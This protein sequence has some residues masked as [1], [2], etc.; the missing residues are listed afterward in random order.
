MGTSSVNENINGLSIAMFD[1]RRVDGQTLGGLSEVPEWRIPSSSIS[2]GWVKKHIRTCKGK[3][4]LDVGN[5]RCID[6]RRF[7]K[8]F[9]FWSVSPW[10]IRFVSPRGFPWKLISLATNAPR[11]SSGNAAPFPMDRPGPL[12]DVCWVDRWPT[13]R[14]FPSLEWWEYMGIYGNWIREII[15]GRMV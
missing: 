1:S 9:I 10:V 8:I 6:S 15:K 12:V 14:R 5:L 11:P 3:V 2:N 7:M 13:S 4:Y